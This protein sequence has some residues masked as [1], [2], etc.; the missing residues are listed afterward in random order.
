LFP[1]SR[2]PPSVKMTAW[3]MVLMSRFN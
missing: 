1:S 2:V 3:M